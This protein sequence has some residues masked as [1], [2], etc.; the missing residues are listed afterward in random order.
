MAGAVDLSIAT[1]DDREAGPIGWAAVLR[2]GEHVKEVSGVLSIKMPGQTP[3]LLVAAHALEALKRPSRVEIHAAA[4]KPQVSDERYRLAERQHE[5]KW[6]RSTG[7]E[8]D[9]VRAETLARQARPEP[10]GRC[11]HDLIIDQCWECRSRPDGLPGRVAVTSGG[12]VFHVAAGCAALHD[13]WRQVDRRGGTPSDLRWVPIAD[14][15]ATGRGGCEVCCAK[16]SL[17]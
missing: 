9:A 10:D 13:G 7:E 16:L 4:T 11:R 17:P 8:A 15:L 14:A 12:S 1:T 3:I 5:V 2:Y 6:V